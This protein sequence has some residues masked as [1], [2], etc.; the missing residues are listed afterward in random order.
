MKPREICQD[1]DRSA[2]GL[3]VE[4]RRTHQS[5]VERSCFDDGFLAVF[6]GIQMSQDDG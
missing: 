4:D 5:P 6:V 3:V 2:R 1:A